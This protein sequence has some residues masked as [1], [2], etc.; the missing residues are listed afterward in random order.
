MFNASNYFDIKNVVINEVIGSTWLYLVIMGVVILYLGA[1]FN[2]DIRVTVLFLYIF[3]GI[4]GLIMQSAV[5][6]ATVVA[7]MMFGVV[8]FTISK[9]LKSHQ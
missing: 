2:M 8:A 9:L 3:V 5:V 6:I 1:K 7:V 4:T